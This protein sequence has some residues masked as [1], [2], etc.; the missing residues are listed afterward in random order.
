MKQGGARTSPAI[1]GSFKDELDRQSELM[2]EQGDII[3]KIQLRMEE[4]TNG[5]GTDTRTMFY[6]GKSLNSEADVYALLAG[7]DVP[8]SFAAIPSI[9][10]IGSRM[11]KIMTGDQGD[12]LADQLKIQKLAKELEMTE[13]ECLHISVAGQR[14]IGFLSG[15][16]KVGKT[17]YSGH[18]TNSFKEWRDESNGVG[19]AYDLERALVTVEDEYNSII[20]MYFPP[21]FD[22]SSLRNL[23]YSVLAQSLS[24]LKKFIIWTDATYRSLTIKHTPDDQ[25]WWIITKVW[26]AIFEDFLGPA[27]VVPTSG[28]LSGGALTARYIWHTL[29]I[30]LLCKE[31]EDK[32]I[33]NHHIVH[34]VYSEWLVA[35]SGRHEADVAKAEAMKATAAVSEF[36]ATIKKLEDQVDK[37]KKES[38]TAKQVADRAISQVKSPKNG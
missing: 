19:F 12:S 28:G 2:V 34:G 24:F 16:R 35:H 31:L 6:G 37:A 21:T 23:A 33:K 22:S 38:A 10:Q 5:Q 7:S 25:A 17:E 36:R 27:R 3:K 13:K 32:E 29:Q 11:S 1:A 30:H 15:T 20:E 14:R 9:Y 4:E 8:G 18:G 26:K